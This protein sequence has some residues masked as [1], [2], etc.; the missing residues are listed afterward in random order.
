MLINYLYKLW[1]IYYENDNL[2][3]RMESMPIYYDESKKEF[4]LQAKNTSYMMQIVKEGY[5]AHVYWGKKVRNSR[6]PNSLR[7]RDRGFSANP[8][9]DDRTFSLDTL[10]LEY[11]AYGNTDFR[12]PAIHVGSEDGA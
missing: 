3:R 9:K 4:H 6:F 12:K 11:P 10:P 1:D 8:N 2:L 7:Y 5:L